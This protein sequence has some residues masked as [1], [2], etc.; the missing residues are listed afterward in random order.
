MKIDKIK[1]TKT[2]YSILLDNGKTITTYEE[3]ILKYGLLYHKFIDDKMIKKI[4][5]D[6]NYYENYNKIID[7]INRRLRSEYEIRNYLTK[8]EVENK[9]IEKIINKLK[10]IKLIDDK[11]YAKAYIND[12]IN[13]SSDGPYKIK[14]HLEENKIDEEYIEEAFENI[15]KSQIEKRIDKIIEK[16]IKNNKKH[17]PSILKQKITIYLINLG[18]SKSDITERLNNYKIDSPNLQREMDKIL[19]NLIKKYDGEKLIFNLKRKL[20][21][22][23]YSREEIENYIKNSSLI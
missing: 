1:K 8:K 2:K 18:Y 7:M 4:F 17:T 3:V 21:S 15:G 10:T 9:D 13:L 12:K 23:G 16:R 11:A 20:Y 6:T 22:K 5:M 14:K 19:N